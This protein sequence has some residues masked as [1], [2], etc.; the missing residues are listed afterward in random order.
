MDSSLIEVEDIHSESMSLDDIKHGRLELTR[1]PAAGIWNGATRIELMHTE[2]PPSPN[3]PLLR[4]LMLLGNA[5]LMEVPPLFFNHMPLLHTLDLS[6]TSIT[7]LPSSLFGLVELRV[8]YL[9]GCELFLELSPEIGQLKKLEELDLN[10]T[11]ITHVPIEM[12]ELI[13]LQKLCLSFY[14]Y[15]QNIGQVIPKGLISKLTRLSYLSIDVNPDHSKWDDTVQVI[16][17]EISEL[18][19]LKTLILYVPR[20]ELLK[21]IPENEDLDFRLVAG[22]HMQRIISRLPPMVEEK[23]KQSNRSLRFVYGNNG[24]GVDVQQEIRKAAGV[25]SGRIELFSQRLKVI[26]GETE[27]WGALRWKSWNEAMR[28]Q[29]LN[30]FFSPIDEQVDIM[31]QLVAEVDETLSSMNIEIHKSCVKLSKQVCDH[32]SEVQE[33]ND[34]PDPKR[35]NTKSK[36]PETASSNSTVKETRIVAQITTEVDILDDGHKW[37]KHGSKSVKGNPFPRSYYRCG[38]RGCPARK[39]RKIGDWRQNILVNELEIYLSESSPSGGTSEVSAR[40]ITASFKKAHI[41]VDIMTQLVAEVDETLSSMNIEIHKSCVKLSK[42]VC[43]H[44][45]EV[46]KKNDEPDPKRR[47]TKAKV[48]ETASSHST[49]T[50]PRIDAQI[51]TE[52]DILDDGPG[53]RKYGKKYFKGNPFPS[54]SSPSGGTS[55]VSA[56]K[57]TAS[58]EK[59]HTM[60]TGKVESVAEASKPTGVALS[61]ISINE[62]SDKD[63]EHEATR[64]RCREVSNNMLAEK[65]DAPYPEDGDL[66]SLLQKQSPSLNIIRVLYSGNF[67]A[68]KT[69]LPTT[70]N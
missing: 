49:V 50:E 66:D 10:E 29:Y 51:A 32:E 58:F 4:V 60:V 35:R 53:W 28:G 16:L 11:Q 42:Q 38:T 44:E 1:P 33:K 14:E 25:H 64:K 43:D 23:F 40:K 47:N 3:C 46:E 67:N 69:P 63:Q 15:D 18:R 59:A 62:N 39:F 48:P 45:S 61:G 57:I 2:L 21:L 65:L 34:E 30:D 36:V 9:R 27:W 37:R 6:Y 24:D 31:T 5:E 17:P 19:F 13:N 20:V 54:E 70:H 41:M 56:R 12:Q 22:H 55:D 7:D 8:L 68:S 52:V 26:K